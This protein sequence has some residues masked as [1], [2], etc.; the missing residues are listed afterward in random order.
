VAAGISKWGREASPMPRRLP[1][2]RLCYAEV[3]D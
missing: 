3:Y 1:T 2:L